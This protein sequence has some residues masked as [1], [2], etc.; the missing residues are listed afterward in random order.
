MCPSQWK[1]MVILIPA[2]NSAST[3][4]E[5]EI[6]SQATDLRHQHQPLLGTSFVSGSMKSPPR[7]NAQPSDS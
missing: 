6:P 4:R 1:G 2:A 7:G 5:G 3:S